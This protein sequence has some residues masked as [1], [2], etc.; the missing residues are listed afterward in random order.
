MFYIQ[1]NDCTKLAVYDYN[2]HGSRTIILVH[3]WPLSH[4]MFEYQI[5]TLLQ[6]DYRIVTMDIRGFG[7]SDESTC[8]YDYNQLA[9]DLFSIIHQMNLY[10]FALLGFSMGGAI[11]TRYMC[12]YQGY[13][14][15]KLCL[16][17]AAVPTYCQS[18]QNPYGQ[19]VQDTDK[20][21]QLGYHDRPKLNQYFGSIF[22]A[23]KH[24]HPFMNWL[25]GISDDA[26]G[27]GQMQTLFSLRDE[28]VFCDLQSIQVPTAIFH[29]TKDQICRFEMAEIM[30]QNISSSQLFPLKDA[31]HS[32][33]YDNLE[34]F[35]NLLIHFLDDN[36]EKQTT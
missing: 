11:V 8:G 1:S 30:H 9:T 25:Q 21:I 20:L 3:G 29:G 15:S 32:A 24:S 31:G 22:F 27:L 36:N 7:Q 16:L 10:N 2:P 5:P 35:N 14:V 19:S 13:G 18:P 17:D 23:K 6:Y 33:F 34:E 28:N 4:K 26:S 12:L